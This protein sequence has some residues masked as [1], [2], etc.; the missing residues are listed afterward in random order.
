M[1]INPV[2]KEQLGLVVIDEAH[3]VSQ[4]GRGFR[5]DYAWLGQLRSLFGGHV[6]W[7]A[8]S[9][10]LEAEAL[11]E[12][13]KGVGFEDDVT[14]MCMSI[15]QPELVIRIGWIPK[16][17][18]QKASALCFIFDEGSQMDAESTAM[19][20]QIPKTVVFFDSKKDA[21]AA[22]QECRNWLQESDK[23]KYL[24]KQAREMIKVFHHDTAKFDKEVIIAKFQ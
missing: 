1:A 22:I 4:W 18:H 11:K 5:T 9:A 20:Q 3:L 23:H 6:P 12:L 7:F 19:P 15:D 13:K 21:Y 2:F 17:S 10:T 14:I 24:K 8:C 16:N